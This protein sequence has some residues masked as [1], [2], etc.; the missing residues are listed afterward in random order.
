MMLSKH[1]RTRQRRRLAGERALPQSRQLCVAGV[2][3]AS[4]LSQNV[5][6]ADGLC[7]VGLLNQAVKVLWKPQGSFRGVTESDI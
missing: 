6:E 4:R 3:V 1:R 5:L 2:R 7:V